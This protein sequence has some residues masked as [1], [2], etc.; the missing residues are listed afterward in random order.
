MGAAVGLRSSVTGVADLAIRHRLD[1]GGE[2]A[3][4]TRAQFRQVLIAFGLKT[5]TGR[6]RMKCCSTS[7]DALFRLH[8]AVDDPHQDD[9]AEIDVVPAIDQQRLQRRVDI[10]LWA[11]AVD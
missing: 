7:A 6:Y 5:P 11:A 1:A 3:D 2:E 9:D 4:L 8:D 10:A